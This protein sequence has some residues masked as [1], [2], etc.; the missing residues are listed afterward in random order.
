DNFI[1]MDPPKHDVQRKTV[2]PSVA[3]N[4]LARLERVI[5][6]RVV[7]I[8]DDL[9]PGETFNWVDRVSIELTARMLATLFDFPYEQRRKLV[10]WSDV[11]TSSPQIMGD[12]GMP[13]AQRAAE[14]GEC[15]AAFTELWRQRASQ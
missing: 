12:A 7:D 5:R 8:L 9:P 10:H 11:T 4:N 15:V 2:A 3:P 1:A 13:A 6:E 14:L